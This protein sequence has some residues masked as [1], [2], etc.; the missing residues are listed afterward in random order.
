MMKKLALILVAAIFL[1]MTMMAEDFKFGSIN[2]EEVM[3]LLPEMN[4][5]EKAMTK[6]TEDNK[7][8]LQG[9]EDEMKQAY[10]KY[11]KEKPSMT[12]SIAKMEEEK[13]VEMQQRA[14]TAYQTIQTS[15][16][17]K[18]KELL[19]PMQKKV[20]DAIDVVGKKNGFTFIFQ[21]GGDI[22]YKSEKVVD[23]TPLVKKE[24]G[25]LQ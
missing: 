10:E 14:Q 11:Q 9:L 1:P 17:Q 8:Y 5:Y 7:K 2:A 21:V 6:E 15:L 22:L 4:D 3:M 13:L 20:K 19:A 24:L 18:Q 25:I 23:V 16:Q 12:E